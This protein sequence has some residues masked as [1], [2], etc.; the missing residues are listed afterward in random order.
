MNKL[1]I[2]PVSGL[3]E[4]HPIN[5]HISSR[6]KFSPPSI[7]FSQRVASSTRKGNRIWGSERRT[8]ES[9]T[10]RWTRD[11]LC[12][13]DLSIPT[14]SFSLSKS[15]WSTRRVDQEGKQLLSDDMGYRSLLGDASNIHW[16]RRE[17]E[18]VAWCAWQACGQEFLAGYP[19]V[20][21]KLFAIVPFS[22]VRWNSSDTYTLVHG[23]RETEWVTDMRGD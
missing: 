10:R 15:R 18:R 17:R 22:V 6:E 13:K 4:T 11:G 23:E 12:R 21:S 19:R 9:K 1:W 8:E 20:A 3:G 14:L 7:F 5:G 2:L 16:R